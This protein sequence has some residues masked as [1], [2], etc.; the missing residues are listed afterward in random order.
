MLAAKGSMIRFWFI[1]PIQSNNIN[2]VNNKINKQEQI[3]G[4]KVE[5]RI[6][7]IIFIF[8]QSICVFWIAAPASEY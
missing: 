2:T 7:I 3:K 8:T 5:F 4:K 6:I 1:S